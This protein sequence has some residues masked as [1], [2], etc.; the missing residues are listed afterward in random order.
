MHAFEARKSESAKWREPVALVDQS[1]F[2]CL[3]IETVCFFCKGDAK[4]EPLHEFTTFNADKSV[5]VMATEMNDTDILVKLADVAIEA[6]YHL[7][8]LTK[9]RNQYRSHIRSDQRSSDVQT[10]EVQKAKAMAFAKTVYIENAL[11]DGTFIFRLPD[12]HRL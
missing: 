9:Y 12:V 11:D 6:K 7:A 5:K 4:A 10:A 1:V 3:Y 8:C 2:L